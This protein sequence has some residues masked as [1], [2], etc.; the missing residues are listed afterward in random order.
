MK[1]RLRH[2]IAAVLLMVFMLAGCSAPPSNT[3]VPPK[4]SAPTAQKAT[5]APA[6]PTSVPLEADWTLHVNQ[7]ITV[8]VEGLPVNH[9]LILVAKKTR[10]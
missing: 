8:E 1:P 2:L 6:A 10:Y 9:T 7:T 3:P 4:P 5:S